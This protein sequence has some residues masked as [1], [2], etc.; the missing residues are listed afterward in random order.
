MKRLASCFD[1]ISFK[2]ISFVE[3]CNYLAWLL[4][5]VVKVIKKYTQLVPS[6][7]SIMS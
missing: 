6:L 5:L 3:L 2:I 1:V 7:F 4:S